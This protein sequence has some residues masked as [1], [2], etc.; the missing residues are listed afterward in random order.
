MCYKKG[1]NTPGQEL[2][3]DLEDRQRAQRRLSG[4]Q[5]A[6]SI[7]IRSLQEI[8]DSRGRDAEL[9]SAIRKPDKTC[10]EFLVYVGSRGSLLQVGLMK[11]QA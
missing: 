11:V 1:F 10:P 9:Y 4:S 6:S 5:N 7:S 2:L 3:R 8:L